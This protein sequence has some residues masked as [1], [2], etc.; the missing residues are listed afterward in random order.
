[1]SHLSRRLTVIFLG[2]FILLSLATV[3]RHE[4]WRDELQ[5]WLL[6]KEQTSLGELASASRYEKHP[7]A[8][9]VGLFL[10]SRLTGSP[11]AMQLFH[12]GLAALSAWLVLRF[13][14]F[15]R[16]QKVLL[17]F[18]YYLF[19][20]Y[21]IISRNYALGALS[22]FL[23]CVFFTREPAKPLLSAAC[24]FVLANTSV[25][26]LILALA[27]GAVMLMNIL[28]DRSMRQKWA[29]YAALF[30]V[31]VG[32]LLCI[33]YLRPLPD[34]SFDRAS[35]IQTGFDTD[36]LTA[37]LQTLP[38]S[39]LAMPM[40]IFHFWNTNFLDDWALS[41]LPA[42]AAS[43]LLILI[44][45]IVLIRKSRNAIIFYGLAT[46]GILAFSYLVNVGLIRHYGHLFLAFMA[47]LWLAR[48]SF[49]S[50]E[51]SAP[52]MRGSRREGSMALSPVVTLILCVQAAGGLFAAG[53]DIVH[54]F[55]QSK[56]VARYIRQKGYAN[57]P[58]VG[59]MDYLMT[60]VSGYLGRLVYFVRGERL[61]SYVKW[62]MKRFQEV[63]PQRILERAEQFTWNKRKDCLILLNSPL[64]P[65][66]ERPGYLTKLMATDRAVV[67]GEIYWLYLLKYTGPPPEVPRPETLKR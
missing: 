16:V 22:L 48:S 58:I 9:F 43:A 7:M 66:L 50:A 27:A 1:M 2:L 19:F 41:T 15:S 47:A 26:G 64:D 20:E 33:L 42:I 65:G 24:L 34:S 52:T 21:N 49:A 17:I 45:A 11:L 46:T 18:S 32:G 28:S 36:L 57:L 59:E 54:P 40:P 13:A 51:I 10:L 60:P 67:E 4:M 62:D 3:L 14:P 38:R 29:S 12:V 31:V 56:A 37:V 8:W 39:F 55:S 30:I 61:G 5:A 63:T 25:Y 53:M 23:F 6:A 44:F 35:K